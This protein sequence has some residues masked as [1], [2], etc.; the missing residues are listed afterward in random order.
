MGAPG[1]IPAAAPRSIRLEPSGRGWDE[2]EAVRAAANRELRSEL[3]ASGVER[4]GG[5]AGLA[6]LLLLA[7]LGALF[8][9]ADRTAPP[10][11]VAFPRFRLALVLA[12]V[13]SAA[14]YAA[15]RS[16]RLRRQHVHDL[17]SAYLVLLC[18]LIAVMRHALPWN[19]FELLRQVSPAVVP[20]LAFGALIPATPRGSVAT[21]LLAAA[22]D[23]LSLYASNVGGPS[24]SPGVFLLS[25]ASPFAAALLAH[26]I[27]VVV[28]R[29]SEGAERA[30]E[31]G[32]YELVERLG[33]GG[34]AEVWRANHLML[35]SPAAVKL[36]RPEVLEHGNREA[37][38]LL[39][40]FLREARTTASLRSPHTIQVYDFGI[41][42]EGA[43]Y[44]VMELLNGVDLKTLVERFG[45]QNAER[46]A[47]LLRQVCHSLAEAHD[48]DFVHRDVKPANVFTCLQGGDAD[49]VKVLDFGL[50]LDRHPTAA[51]LEDE[52]RFV[53]TPA[54]MAPE[55]VRFQAPVDA[56]A[57]LYAVGCV[58]YWL[59]TGK[60][61]FEAATRHD[62]LVMHAHQK[63]L[64]PSARVGKPIHAELEALIMTCLEKNP[65]KRPQTARELAERLLA[66]HFEPPWTTE[67]ASLWWRRERPLEPD[68]VIVP[69][70]R[71]TEPEGSPD[72]RSSTNEPRSAGQPP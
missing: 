35:A 13:S 18:L 10:W 53:G 54:I 49:F 46:T 45:P 59:L 55:M 66:I 28:H 23:P 62:M 19:A 11:S 30:R 22:M 44:Y 1:S 17:G 21:L 5:I 8:A 29:L 25:A 20:I 31:I 12:V 39:R 64:S 2:R 72:T 32:S 3:L 68:T 57:D 70:E 36:I 51:E 71:T 15:A 40:L 24:P 7:A 26:R 56:R 14:V 52:Q 9:F 42:R 4:L 38:R 27:S 34:M 43:F 61:V 60:R 6:G 63:P 48:H 65:D 67:R 33:T 41:T 69:S 58:G 50:V 47:F 37:E 16:E